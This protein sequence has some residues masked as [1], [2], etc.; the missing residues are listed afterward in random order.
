[1][2][3]FYT[4]GMHLSKVAVGNRYFHRA[5]PLT[6]AFCN[7]RYECEPLTRKQNHR[8][9]QMKSNSVLQLTSVDFVGDSGLSEEGKAC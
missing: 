3:P 7:P 2:W 6:I 8:F 4:Q 5:P 9:R 1:M